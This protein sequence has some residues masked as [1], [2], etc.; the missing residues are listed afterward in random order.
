MKKNF[1]II[2]L[3]LSLFLLSC[4]KEVFTSIVEPANYAIGKML[5]ETNPSGFNIYVDNKNMGLKTPDTVKWL[6]P[7]QRKLTIK[8][9]LYPDTSI[10]LN[11][12]EVSL[13]KVKIDVTLNPRFY[14]KLYLKSNPNASRVSL[15]GKPTN[16]ITPAY[17]TSLTPGNYKI[18]FSKNE[19][20]SD[21][22]TL[23]I[24]GGM[25]T[26]YVMELEDT[27]NAVDYRIK[28]SKIISDYLL[29]VL[30]DNNNIK[31][32]GSSDKGLFSYDGKV[33]T[34]YSNY[35]PSN[36]INHLFL[37]SKNRMWISTS[38]GLYYKEGN[39]FNSFDVK[40]ANKYITY[41]NEDKLGNIWICTTDGLFIFENNIL[42]EID[43][44]NSSIVYKSFSCIVFDKNNKAWIG[45]DYYQ[46]VSY[47]KGSWVLESIA[48]QEELPEGLG[49][50]V[51]SVIVNSNQNILAFVYGDP[52]NSAANKLI[53]FDPT[54]S[55]WSVFD[56]KQQFPIQIVSMKLDSN[57]D[58]W[59]SSK[60]G[61][62]RYSN[63]K[64]PILFNT[65]DYSFYSKYCT[66]S[67]MD[68]N[69]I[70]WVTTMGG[71]LIKLKK[72]F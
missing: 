11:V 16:F 38:T 47:Y 71:G 46:L 19:C 10:N 51:S 29:C 18:T 52:R 9:E 7:G 5:V 66:G 57:N 64:A 22:V 40:L 53:Q 67:H 3:S 56:L 31:W 65:Y 13:T 58:L 24:K 20:R 33:F 25:W 70:V 30:V 21:S 43:T 32:I 6:L 35:I 39:S 72:G 69:K 12:S 54:K 27:S 68:K 60:E 2:F 37:D 49:P 17:L 63:I 28:N 59:A 26:E 44:H 23:K 61:L 50:S 41:V 14:A 36:R 48:S 45:T 34:S 42:K 1:Y 4:E 55:S 8:N 62:L 15:N